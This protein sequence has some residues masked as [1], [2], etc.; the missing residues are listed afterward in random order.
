MYSLQ[1]KKRQY[2]DLPD[3]QFKYEDPF[4][5]DCNRLIHAPCFRRLQGKIQLF[6]VGESDFFRNRLTHSLEVEAVAQLIVN[7]INSLISDDPNKINKHVVRFACFSHDIGHP[8]FGHYG[9]KALNNCM[10]NNGGFEANAQ[11]F[12]ILTTIEKGNILYNSPEKH[13]RNGLNITYRN[14]A[15]VVKYFEVIPLCIDKKNEYNDDYPLIKGYYNDDGYLIDEI[16]KNNKKKTIECQIMD[17]A[18]DISNAVFDLEDSLKGGFI[19]PFNL[20]FPNREILD[21]IT[22]HIDKMTLSGLNLINNNKAKN[23][24]DTRNRVFNALNQIFEFTDIISLEI[25]IK[26]NDWKKLVNHIY[27]KA[28][29]LSSNGYYRNRFIKRLINRFIDSIG[30]QDTKEINKFSKITI[31]EDC[32]VQILVLKKFHNLYQHQSTNTVV[33]DFRGG[34]I[35]EKLFNTFKMNP[36]LMS[37]DFYLWYTLLKENNLNKERVISDYISGMTDKY[38]IEVYS[39]IFSEKPESYFKPI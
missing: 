32:Y 19:N 17:I 15:A 11:T 2:F 34:Q 7:K 29:D 13:S 6:P 38:C 12:R 37:N 31:D 9:E 10:A 21:E 30:I 36:K 3:C 33:S 1:D 4:E 28:L 35:I 16:F 5:S 27:N 14:L 18:D 22:D 23:S 20:F 24:I 25:E 26:E 39:R 8:P